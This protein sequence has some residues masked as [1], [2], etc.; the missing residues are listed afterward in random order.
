MLGI[1]ISY[2][3]VNSGID[4][5]GYM[6]ETMV[7][8][9][10]AVSTLIM[11]AWDPNRMALYACLAVVFTILAAIPPAWRVTRMKPVDAMRHN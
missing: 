10:V 9:G 2:P 6:G 3:L 1:G 5:S 7:T 4:M 11:G 8:G